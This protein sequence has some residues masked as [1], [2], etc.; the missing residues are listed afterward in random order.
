MRQLYKTPEEYEVLDK[1]VGE[2]LRGMKYK[3][4]HADMHFFKSSPCATPGG[5]L[6]L[7]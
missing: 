4:R 5:K 3:V 7:L 2:K 1:C 6:A